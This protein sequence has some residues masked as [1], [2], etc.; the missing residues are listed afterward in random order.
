MSVILERFSIDVLPPE[1]WL[2]PKTERRSVCLLQ[3][4]DAIFPGG[5]ISAILGGS[6]S[7]KTT[8]LNVIAGRYD[9]STV[10]AHGSLSFARASLTAQQ[11]ATAVK[12]S[13]SVA[14]VTQDDFLHPHLTVRETLE[15]GA[16]LKIPA[17]EQDLAEQV[18]HDVTMELGLKECM[19][20]VVGSDD[21]T[22]SSRGISGGEKRRVSIALQIL[23]HPQVANPPSLSISYFLFS[24]CLN[25][26]PS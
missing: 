23:T 2:Q 15:Y 12:P 5:E 24:K 22:T 9:R 20:S 26:P 11:A 18:V 3:P 16:R 19:E 7:G 21:G 6:G 17:A 13:C 25:P 4:L 14:Y 8:L 1:N 10:V